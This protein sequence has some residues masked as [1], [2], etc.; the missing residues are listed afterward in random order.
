LA[1]A[2]VF[3]RQAGLAWSDATGRVRAFMEWADFEGGRASGGQPAPKG[4]PRD[5]RFGLVGFNG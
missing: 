2:Q 4:F 3:A 5:G 1:D